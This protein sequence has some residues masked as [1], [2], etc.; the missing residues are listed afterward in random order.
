[1][2]YPREGDNPVYVSNRGLEG[3][4]KR[5]ETTGCEEF[6]CESC[7]YCHQWAEKNV[8]FDPDWRR[9][10][11]GMYDELLSDLHSGSLWEPYWTT[12]KRRISE[13]FRRKTKSQHPG[14]RQVGGEVLPN[15]KNRK[16]GEKNVVPQDPPCT[17][18]K[19]QN[20]VSVGNEGPAPEEDRE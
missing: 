15:V 16:L 9:K 11:T 17:N 7:R 12:L 18:P 14:D 19:P 5:F 20:T 1:M 6:D 4:L 3:F 13:F 10:M 8:Y 2:L